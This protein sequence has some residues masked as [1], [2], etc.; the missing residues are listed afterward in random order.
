MCQ[1]N[2]KIRVWFVKCSKSI[3][4]QL[5]FFPSF[6]APTRVFWRVTAIRIP[7]WYGVSNSLTP[8]VFCICLESVQFAL[9]LMYMHFDTDK[10]QPGVHAKVINFSSLSRRSRIHIESG[11]FR[12]IR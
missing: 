4:L 10:S 6:F 2:N 8:H 3:H 9:G 7:L 11:H 1:L 5:Y 12:Y